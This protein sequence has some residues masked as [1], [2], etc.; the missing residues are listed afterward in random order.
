MRAWAH[1]RTPI[2][3]TY[4]CTMFMRHKS[5]QVGGRWHKETKNI[6]HKKWNFRTRFSVHFCLLSTKNLFFMKYKIFLVFSYFTAWCLYI[7]L[8]I[9][10]NRKR[11]I[12][13]KTGSCQE[14]EKWRNFVIEEKKFAACWRTWRQLPDNKKLNIDYVLIY[15]KYT[16]KYLTTALH[17]IG[18]LLFQPIFA[19]LC[20]KK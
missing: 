4:N 17:L 6:M 15:H 20:M 7:Y 1:A 13:E 16:R 12:A 5:S 10:W 19:Y 2:S 11:N 8:N 14:W 9:L 3:Y 18:R